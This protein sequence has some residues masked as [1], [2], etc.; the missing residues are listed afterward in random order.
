MGLRGMASSFFGQT[1][2]VAI[3]QGFSSHLLRYIRF[4]ELVQWLRTE[5]HSD[6]ALRS[7][8]TSVDT[9]RQTDNS[10]IIQLMCINRILWE[11]REGLPV[12]PENLENA[13]WKISKE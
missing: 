11:Y 10:F 12:D 2:Q 13:S 1:S 4:W 8:Q 7:F 9:N 6:C 5:R 3:A